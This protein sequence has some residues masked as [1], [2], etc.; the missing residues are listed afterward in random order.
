MENI[1]AVSGG[2]NF[3]INAEFVKLSVF[4]SRVAN[5]IGAGFECTIQT[6]GN[7]NWTLMGAPANQVGITFTT[8][9][10]GN[11]DGTA[12]VKSVYTFS[13]AYKAETIN[14]LTY[15][16]LGGLLAVGI[17]QRDLRVT[18]A[19]TSI[20]LSGISGNNIQIVLDNNIRGSQVEIIRGFYDTN[21]NLTSNAHRFTG[22]VTS[23]NIT[24]ER[25]EKEDNFIVTLNCSSFK[26][27]LENRIAGRYT[28]KQSWQV[29]YP[30]DSSVNNIFS[31]SGQYFDFGRKPTRDTNNS[32]GPN[33]PGG[34]GGPGD[35]GG[36]G[37]GGG[38]IEPFHGA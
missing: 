8:I 13:S 24:E 31:I 4:N 12:Y 6:L 17:Q 9:V 37:G 16:P 11:G 33:L 1:P 36:G 19:D 7:T 21:Y 35:G 14:G 18:S 25:V 20:S 26:T 38:G 10:A 29:W 15:N 27:V 2:K 32:S 3:V 28:N 5:T 34:G 30:N 22:I 23:Y